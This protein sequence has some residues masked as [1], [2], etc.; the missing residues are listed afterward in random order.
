M[1][2]TAL[3]EAHKNLGAK[4]VPF[5]G[6]EMPVLY[7][8]IMEEHNAVRNAVGVFD[9]SHMGEF[10]VK[11][12]NALAFLQKITVNDVS[13]L[14]PG[15]VQYSAMCYEN[16]GIVDDLLVYM[17]ADQHYL[18]VVNASN[19]DKDFSWMQQ[20][21]LPDVTLE[22]ESDATSLLAIQGPQSKAVLQK[23]TDVDLN[24][25]EYYHFVHGKVSGIE[26]I[27]SRTG[28]T[29]ELGFEI[30]FPAEHS[31]K[32]WNALFE[33]GKEFGIAP[34]GLAARDSLRLEMG[35]CLYGNDIDQTT[36]PL[37]AGLGW[38]TKLNKGDFIAKPILDAAKKNGA[39]RK[40]VGMM[41]SEKAVP[42]HGYTIYVGNENVGVVTSGTFSPSLEKGI[43]MGYVQ[44]QYAA[45][46][47]KVQIDVRGKH[48]EATIAALPFL[49]K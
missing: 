45:V 41:L 10:I 36:H 28:Y 15:R 35:F 38:I 29:G 13:K 43:A 24:P 46:D 20:H 48:I 4:L 37:E 5:G 9:V 16:G 47:S 18:V 40:L 39:N 2:R 44:A 33:A 49:K 26:M 32:I 3:F 21:L 8:G 22:N 23:L 7:T 30:Y 11:G 31:A 12:N 19:I 34:I 42:R 14:F 1:K 25:I 6:F 17:I 27:I